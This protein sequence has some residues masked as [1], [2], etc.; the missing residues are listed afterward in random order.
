[1]NGQHEPLRDLREVTPVATIRREFHDQ[2]VHA[3]RPDGDCADCRR[4]ARRTCR[5]CGR[6]LRDG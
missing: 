2:G 3:A 6:D 1:M 5:S 4:D